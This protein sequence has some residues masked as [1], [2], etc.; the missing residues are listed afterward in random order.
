M[1][2]RTP[3]YILQR[4]ADQARARE[5][6]FN[7]RNSNPDTFNANVESLPRT[8]VGYRSHLV[9]I[10]STPGPAQLSVTASQSAVKWFEGVADTGNL[11]NANTRL[12]LEYDD[13]SE[14]FPAKGF[15]PAKIKA[16]LGGT[17]R[18]VSTAWGTRYIAYTRSAD[19]SARN[20]YTAPISVRA[21]AVITIEDLQT[22]ATAIAQV[23][24]IAQQIGT[25][26]RLWIDPED[27]NYVIPVG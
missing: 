21:G 20:S 15:K 2:R 14:Y 25:N 26:G 24:A 4:Q 8:R 22:A 12:G 9:S 6:Y 16:S 13:L 27:N 19:G 10:G 18:A 23:A 3:S 7:N 1:S 11:T 17:P 5:D